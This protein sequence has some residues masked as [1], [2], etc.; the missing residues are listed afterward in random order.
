MGCRLLVAGHDELQACFR[1]EP[2]DGIQH[3]ASLVSGYA[4]DELHVLLDEA[5]DQQFRAHYVGHSLL[6]FLPQGLGWKLSS[7]G[8]RSPLSF[9]PLRRSLGVLDASGRAPA[10]TIWWTGPLDTGRA[11][12]RPTQGAVQ[13]T[14]RH[15]R[16]A[17]ST[18]FK[19]RP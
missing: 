13:P 16:R 1:A 10:N 8:T 19:S 14:P 11:S 3:G 5:L 12:L 18:F 4:K 15:T 7:L 6:L 2:A 9:E 17:G